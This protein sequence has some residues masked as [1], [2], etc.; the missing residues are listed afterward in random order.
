MSRVFLYDTTLRDGTQ[1]ENLSLSCND[2]LKIAQR[3]DAFGIHYIE[4]GWPGSN[5]KD[6]EFFSRVPSIGLT[7]A[8]V[9]AFG[10]T[11]YKNTTCEKDSNVQALVAAQTPV[12]TLVG[13]S[14]DLHV[15][16]VLETSAEENL[17]MI[18]ESVEYFKRLGKEVVYDAEHFFDGYKA[19]PEH[20]L[21]T[22]RAAARAGADF[23]VLCDT[24]GGSLPWEV[25]ETFEAVRS[26]L[27]DF[28]S[29]EYGIHA[30]DDGGCA[31][32]N[33]LMAVRGGCSMVQGTINGYGER[34]ANAS[35]TTL[36]PDLQLKMGLSCVS[37]EQLREL[38]P[39][40]RYVAELANITHD[41]NLPY[42]GRSAFAHKGGIHVA[43][44]AKQAVSYQHIDPELVGNGMRVVVSELS[45][46]RNILHLA[47]RQGVDADR[48]HAGEVLDEVKALEN[49]GYS[50][51]GAEASVEL[52]LRRKQEG[53]VRPFEL[54]DF[55][56]V[57]EHRSRR[58]PLAEATVKVRVNDRVE[59]T[60]AEGNGPVNALHTALRKALLDTYPEVGLV[61]LSDYKVRILDSEAGTAA[62]TRVLIDFQRGS[63]VWTTVGASANI[64]E[65]TWC[66]LEDA[67]EYALLP[68]S[69][70]A[71]RADS[72]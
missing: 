24:N 59:H 13:K 53:Y 4:G 9:C 7:Q 64:I 62:T 68:H 41:D 26:A 25:G 43:A 12:V 27:K 50:F 28:T 47:G 57:V 71:E 67:M 16:H 14:W 21:E 38:T 37:P 44:M 8:K 34:V 52:M 66:A 56:V 20:T 32:A 35:L 6:A 31:V 22:L 30:H 55:M 2:K 33:S 49:K 51:E 17:A 23:L 58:G 61:R 3:L 29:V 1:R 46:R 19:N 45:G 15:E 72:A 60:A 5:P 40:S 42:V 11:R 70:K 18:S 69:E 10:S 48:G 39:L 65:A 63:H 36:V 54:V